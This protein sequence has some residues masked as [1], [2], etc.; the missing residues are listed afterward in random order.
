VDGGAT[1]QASAAVLNE[2][3]ADQIA[4]TALVQ[5]INVGDTRSNGRPRAARLI[6]SL[7]EADL[8]GGYSITLSALASSVSGICR[9]RFLLF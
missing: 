7:P 5:A 2:N 3:C 6:R 4:E 1:D 8:V 9:S